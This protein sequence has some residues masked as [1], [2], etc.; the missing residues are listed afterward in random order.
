MAVIGGGSAELTPAMYTTRLDN[1]TVVIN[2]SGD[3]DRN[4]P[5]SSNLSDHLRPS[6]L[7]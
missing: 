2:R 6:C 3:R 4:D 7:Q 5:H 1:D